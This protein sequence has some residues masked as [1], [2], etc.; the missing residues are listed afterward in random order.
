MFSFIE[1]VENGNAGGKIYLIHIYI[2][3]IFF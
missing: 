2:Y 3:I 1:V